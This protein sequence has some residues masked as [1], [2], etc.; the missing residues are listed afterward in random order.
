MSITIL[1]Q[2]G[3]SKQ[4]ISNEKL[5]SLARDAGFSM[6]EGS[7]H[8][9]Y[10]HDRYPDIHFGI[11]RGRGKDLSTLLLI[12]ALKQVVRRD[13]EQALSASKKFA[14][15]AEKESA[16]RLIAIQ[17]QLP[18]YV[19]AFY[20]E[21][22]EIIIRDKQIPQIGFTLNTAAEDYLLENKLRHELDTVK[23]EFHILLSRSTMQYDMNIE[24]DE[25]GTFTGT[26]SHT[27]YDIDDVIL[28]PYPQSSD[29]FTAILDYQNQVLEIDFDHAARKQS[30]LDK[31]D[32]KTVLVLHSAR[33]G[34]RTNQVAYKPP[35]VKGTLKFTFDTF[36]NQRVSGDG[37]TSR[38]S[39]DEL[40]KL[41]NIVNAIETKSSKQTRPQ[42]PALTKAA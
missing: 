38:I 11:S 26:L 12:D 32:V 13:E 22:S 42:A 1:E 6:R 31:I 19:E 23:R 34:D 30:A 33:R 14:Q 39:E 36:S 40:N 2:L 24:F 27:L 21:N 37:Q 29:P 15:A 17:E 10:K 28:P 9:R 8:G 20:G 7:K 5:V 16:E 3:D 4:A 41:E 35:G 18:P 25:N